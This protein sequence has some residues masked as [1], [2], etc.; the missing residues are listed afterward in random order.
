[1]RIV[2]G[3]DLVGSGWLGFGLTDRHDCNIYLLHDGGRAVL[4]DAGCGL[5]TERLIKNVTAAGVSP[6]SIDAV[7]ITH[8]HADH[9]G[10][11]AGLA[12]T[13]GVPILASPRVAEILSAA[14]EEAAGLV[15]AREQGIY[16]KDLRLIPTPG[17]VAI[18]GPVRVG[19][20]IVTPVA[21][22]GHAAG[23]LCFLAEI[24]G[25]RALYTGDLVFSRGRTAILDTPDT[26]V[27]LLAQSLRLARSL[28]PDLLLP[29]HGEVVLGDI[30]AH[31]AAAI[32]AFASGRRP[33]A[34]VP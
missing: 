14:D 32:D 25:R 13:L 8:S 10:G 29:G 19:S 24:G 1:M 31:L 3:V 34:M 16:P 5:A 18:D 23:H 17:I 4:I 22:P 11:A 21:T 28:Q 26:D 20:A 7:L 30:D 9:S 2:N 27:G 33:E 6:R 15:R 12:R